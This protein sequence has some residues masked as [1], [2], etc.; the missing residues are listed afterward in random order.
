MDKLDKYVNIKVSPTIRRKL[1]IIAANNDETII[2]AIERMA[3]KELEKI[4]KTI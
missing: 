2:K 1:R 4:K 3:D